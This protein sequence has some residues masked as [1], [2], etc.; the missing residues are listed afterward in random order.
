MRFALDLR[1]Q[2][3]MAQY[4]ELYEGMVADAVRV[5]PSEELLKC[6]CGYRRQLQK[7]RADAE[8]Q[9]RCDPTVSHAWVTSE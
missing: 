8:K 3:A 1:L 2:H 4:R 7:C 5:M 9:K 6:Y